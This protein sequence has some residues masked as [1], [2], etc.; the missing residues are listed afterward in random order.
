MIPDCTLTTACFDL[1]QYNPMSR[2]LIDSINSMKTLLE[3]PCYLVVYTDTK[4]VDLIK[5]IRN[6]FELDHLTKYIVSDFE[7]LQY[8]KYNSIIKMNRLKYWPTRDERTSS[9]SH[10][11]CCHKFQFVLD[12]MRFNPF[13]TTR[14]GWIDANLQ[15]NFTKICQDYNKNMLLD[16]LNNDSEKF[17][18]QILNVNDKKYKEKENKREYYNSYKWVVCGCL[19]ITGK[20]IG[21]KI[22]NRLNNIF[23]E[24]TE[25]GY[26]HGEEMLYLEILDEF[27]HHI[28][29]SYGDYGQILNNYFYPTRNLN[30]IYLYIIKNYLNNNYHKECYHCCKKV[31]YSI[32]E[33]N[34]FCQSSTYLKIL[35]KCYVASYYFKKDECVSIVNHI[36]D[37]CS[38]NSEVKLEFEKNKSFYETQ[39]AFVKN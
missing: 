13:N 6:H 2:N 31:L 5:E 27:Y 25:L 30:Y 19:F 12:T 32:E 24:T 33:H 36:Y 4:C 39:F 28:V 26:G 16:I 23:E 14:F 10:L 34:I 8:Y 37:V 11:L 17:H 7:D 35:F 1:T 9:E 3:V 22:L 15:P 29:P 18:I 38:K 21:I 20:E